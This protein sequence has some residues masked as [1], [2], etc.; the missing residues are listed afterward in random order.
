MSV[1]IDDV[2]IEGHYIEIFQGSYSG[3][4]LSG[5]ALEEKGKEIC[6][7]L[8]Q[9]KK[10]DSVQITDNYKWKNSGVWEIVEIDCSVDSSKAPATYGFKLTFKSA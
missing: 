4:I 6:D 10:G 9:F 8:K 1:S 3:L 7:A 2:E 5:K